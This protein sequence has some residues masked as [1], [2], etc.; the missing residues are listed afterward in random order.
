MTELYDPDN[1]RKA[2]A[3]GCALTVG[4]MGAIALLGLIG[5]LL[6]LIAE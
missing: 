3:I 2:T 6:S 4:A 1:E 5:W